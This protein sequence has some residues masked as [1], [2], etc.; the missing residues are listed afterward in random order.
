MTGHELLPSVYP[1]RLPPKAISD[2][3]DGGQELSPDEASSCPGSPRPSLG[4]V[5]DPSKGLFDEQIPIQEIVPTPPLFQ[6]IVQ[7]QWVQPGACAIPSG[8]DKRLYIVDPAFEELL[9]LPPVDTPV[10]SLTFLPSFRLT[11]WRP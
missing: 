10:A 9:K 5:R 6:T 8:A 1:S 11:Y 3:E 7:R 2:S 4:D